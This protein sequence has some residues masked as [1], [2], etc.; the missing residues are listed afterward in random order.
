MISVTRTNEYA[1]NKCV[2]CHYKWT[3]TIDVDIID[4]YDNTSSLVYSKQVQ[5]PKC[6]KMTDVKKTNNT[7]E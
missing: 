7:N 2:R 5:C 1:L 6:K 3:A 4:W